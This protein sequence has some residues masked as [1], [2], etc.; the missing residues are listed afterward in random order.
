MDTSN[1][2]GQVMEQLMDTNK[3][4]LQCRALQL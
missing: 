3:Q 1:A 2:M 4:A